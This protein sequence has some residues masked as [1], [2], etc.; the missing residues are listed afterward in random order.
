MVGFFLK[1]VVLVREMA[2]GGRK[3][4][5]LST[6]K[7]TSLTAPVAFLRE[8]H[9]WHINDKRRNLLRLFLFS[10]IPLGLCS[11]EI[12]LLFSIC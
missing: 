3:Q 4:V 8:W 7:T 10:V 5:L 9:K 12:K 11:R 6:L 2:W 1:E